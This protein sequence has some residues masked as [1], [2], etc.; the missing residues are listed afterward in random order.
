MT[1]DVKRTADLQSLCLA[2]TEHA[3]LPMAMVEGATHVVRYAN[4]AFCRLMKQPIDDLVGKRISELLPTK[5]RCLTLLDRVWHTRKPESVIEQDKSSQ[6]HSLFWSYLMWPVLADE[7]LVGVM[8]QV[9]ETA[10]IRSKMVAMNEALVISSIGQHELAAMLK[11]SQ[12]RLEQLVADRTARLSETVGELEAFS[13]SIAHDMRA[14]LRAISAFARLVQ[15]EHSDQ[16]DEMGRDYLGRVVAAAKRLDCLITDVLSYSNSSRKELTL[17]NV[18]LN[19]LLK[20]AIQNQPEFVLPHAEIALQQPM[21][22]VFAHEPLLMQC[23]NNLLANAVKFVSPGVFPHVVVR[24]EA[25][26]PDVRLWFEDNGIG[27]P[28]EAQ[29]RIFSLFGR[30]NPVANFEGSGIGL[31]IVRKAVERMGGQVGVNSI[32]GQGSQFWIQLKRGE[33]V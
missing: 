22:V 5:D 10:E 4:P 32:P 27:I 20:E 9:T 24:S 7:C 29:E 33:V 3:P 8:I 11:G 12:D 6:P 14:P 13:Y 18:G 1:D 30:L 21:L 17:Q 2:L 16:I 25:I 15:T 28:I 26:G 31:T 23:I 19:T